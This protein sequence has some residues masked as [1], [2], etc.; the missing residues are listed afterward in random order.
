L[1]REY[2]LERMNGAERTRYV[3][4]ADARTRTRVPGGLLQLQQDYGNRYVQRLVALSGTG[5]CGPKTDLDLASTPTRQPGPD[6]QRKCSC[7]GDAISA[8]DGENRQVQRFRVAGS[9]VLQRACSGGTWINESDGCSVPANL[10]GFLGIDPNNPAGG[11]D[12]QFGLAIP[13]SAGGRACD[14]HDER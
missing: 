9:P 13:S 11:S 2:Q 14:R 12:T 3:S 7:G 6:V 8:G 10:A 4:G 1:T 5:G